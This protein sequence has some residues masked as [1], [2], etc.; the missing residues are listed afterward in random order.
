MNHAFS[1]GFLRALDRTRVLLNDFGK[2]FQ[3]VS[4]ATSAQTA[5]FLQT[6][7]GTLGE[8][9]IIETG[10]GFSSAV[11]PGATH[12]ENNP[13]YE[14]RVRS[15]LA[16]IGVPEGSFSGY[17]AFHDSNVDG[18]FL[19]F[20]DGD[21]ALRGH[22]Q[23]WLQEKLDRAV[24]LI[25]D[26]QAGTFF[27]VQAVLDALMADPRGRLID[28][29]EW[30][31][32]EYGRSASLWIGDASGVP[33][34]V[35]EEIVAGPPAITPPLGANLLLCVNDTPENGRWECTVRALT[36]IGITVD[37][38][39]H[40]LWIIDNG[41]TCPNTA[42]FLDVWCRDQL[43]QNARLRVFRLPQNLYAT[44]AFNRLL[45]MTPPGDYVIRME[46]DIEFHS[47]DWPT[48][49]V[50]FLALSGF[51]L[52]ST[53][54]LDLTSKAL[55]IPAVDVCGTRVQ[56]VDEVPGYCTAIGPS[57]RLELG[58]LFSVGQYI[59][60]VLT[61][62]RA[63]SL[64]YRAAYIDSSEVR[65]FHVDRVASDS[66][67]SWKV[68]AVA[69]EKQAMHDALAE[70]AGGGRSPYIPFQIRDDDGFHELRF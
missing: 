57:L 38:Q 30:T 13:D 39:Q 31:R 3:P 4:M 36:S 19:L 56:V 5:A 8:H 43:S 17:A 42:R 2:T 63:M 32:D 62:K 55:G 1:H 60:D 37:L 28:C 52:V 33:R 40:P 7:V 11:L 69:A 68:Q 25:D 26:A 64:G 21:L 35:I 49:L 53:K 22:T 66:Y 6:L 45:A 18:A 54:P 65:C 10:C 14:L 44:Y 12:V 48:T 46:N 58:S 16:R 24:V 27:Q 34:E 15:W 59:E 23:A 20:L 50:R 61:S 67:L 29:A 47:L 9:R 41:S 51:G 70:W